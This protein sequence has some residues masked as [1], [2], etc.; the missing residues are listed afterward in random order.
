MKKT[1]PDEKGECSKISSSVS[2]DFESEEEKVEE[3]LRD[4]VYMARVLPKFAPHLGCHTVNDVEHRI[5]SILMKNQYNIICNNSIFIVF[6]KKKSS[7]VQGQFERCI[8]SFETKE[9]TANAI[10]IRAKRTNL[11]FSPREFVVV[12]N[13][14]CVSNKDDFVFD[15]DLP[16]RFIEDYFGGAKYIQKRE[17]FA[18]FSEKIWRKDNDED[19]VKLANFYFIHAFLLSAV[20]TVFIPRLHFDLVESDRY[21]DYP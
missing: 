16:N 9:S 21:N 12:T 3:I 7:L 2:S 4:Q 1:K 8:T 5:K 14:N 20:D 13:L 10:V 17:L 11:H 18:A 15:E 19:G 6:M